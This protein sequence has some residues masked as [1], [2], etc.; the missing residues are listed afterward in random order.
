MRAEPGALHCDRPPAGSCRP[1]WRFGSAPPAGTRPARGAHREPTMITR[2]DCAR[3]DADDPLRGLRE[4]FTL[5]E[6]VVYLDGNSLGALPRA[7]PAR[8][9]EAVQREW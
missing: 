7:T 1:S 4:L 6:G 8:V 3:L 2:E 9:A 5:P